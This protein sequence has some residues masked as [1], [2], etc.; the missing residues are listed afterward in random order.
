MMYNKLGAWWHKKCKKSKLCD[1]I[2]D[3]ILWYVWT[4][5]RY[6]YLTIRQWF[7]CNFNVYHWR[8][9]KQA[10]LTQPWD[11]GFYLAL[12]ECMIDKQIHWF[13]HHQMMVDEQY[14][15]IMSSL[16]LAKYC[17][18]VMNNDCDLFHYDGEMKTIPEKFVTDEAGN[19]VTV[20]V[21]NEDEA[22]V[23]R[24][25]N[26]DSRYVY[27][28]PR[29]NKRNAH[30]FMSKQTIELDFFKNGN[31]DHNLYIAKCRH[32]YYLIRERYTD[33]WWD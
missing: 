17:I 11:G 15:E 24:L 9:V 2:D 6:R 32:L 33:L 31:M 30:R 8:L 1:W 16:R 26:S 10:F 12:E 19:R 29:V 25:D 7:Y 4:K 13:E 20:E 14:N 3:N 5:P 21:D 23:Y 22:D 27:D 28:G 18:H